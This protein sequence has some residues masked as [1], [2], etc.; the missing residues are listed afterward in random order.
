[1]DIQRCSF[2]RPLRGVNFIIVREDGKVLIQKRCKSAKVFP[3][4]YCFPG[5]GIEANETPEEA[6]IREIYEETS[7]ER[8]DYTLTELLDFNYK[9]ENFYDCNRF[10]LC[11]TDYPEKVLSLEGKMEWIDLDDIMRID[12]VLQEEQIAWYLIRHLAFLVK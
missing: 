8:E 11:M 9:I 5:G 7:L 10:Y 3:N 4:R 12:I 1:M 2:N 6:V